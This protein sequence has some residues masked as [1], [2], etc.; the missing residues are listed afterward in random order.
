M[1]Q[2]A[3]LFIALLLTACTTFN[4][5]TSSG[6]IDDGKQLGT[7]RIPWPQRQAQLSALQNWSA[8]GSAAAHANNKGWNAYYH[9][10]QNNANYSLIMFGPLG[11][12]RMQITGS[13]GQA[14]LITP[15]QKT[16]TA[17]NPETLLLQ[18][19]GW[20]LPVSDL[21][22]WLRGLPDPHS[23]FKR[24]FDLSNHLANLYQDGWEIRYLR[25]VS[26]NNIDL[27][28][29]ILLSN[30]QWQVRLVISQWQL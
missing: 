26:V 4:A 15:A 30:N 17:S 14:T 24:S 29:R 7:H 20:S 25:Y 19:T 8:Q 2:F 23:R 3:L 21:Y 28:D 6:L 16:F 5:E 9:W 13:P 10:Q 12:D 18:Q 11:M 22:Y 27:P 1:K